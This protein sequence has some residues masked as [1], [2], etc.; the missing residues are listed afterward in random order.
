MS[1]DCILCVDDEA[2]ILAS[3]KVELRKEF[4]KDL[5]IEI[6]MSGEEGLAIAEAL[7]SEGRN[8]LVV[9]TDQRMPHIDGSEFLIRLKARFPEVL[10]IMLTGFS[11]I[12]AIKR[13]IYEASLFRF[14]SKP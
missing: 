14:I 2:I 11:E 4:G 5:D 12:E 7:E 10:G 1:A 9:V 6:A 13:A 8:L 3:L